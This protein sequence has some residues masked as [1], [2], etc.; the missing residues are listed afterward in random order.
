MHKNWKFIQNRWVK[1]LP[2]K[3]WAKN[4]TI[5]ALFSGKIEKFGNLTGVIDLTNMADGSGEP[6][7]TREQRNILRATF[8]K[9][10]FNLNE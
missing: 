6:S 4:I 9:A 5:Y 2:S 10:M 8:V 1:H 3:F 7:P